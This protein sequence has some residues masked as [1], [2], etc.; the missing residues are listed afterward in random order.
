[1]VQHVPGNLIGLAR[2]T[3][4][5][6]VLLAGDTFHNAA[7]IRPSPHLH[8]TYPIPRAI[9]EDS[10]REI[11]REYFFAPDDDTDLSNR[12]IPF[13]TV[14]TNAFYFDPALSRVAQFKLGVF[15]SNPD[16]LVLSS[17]DPSMRHLLDFFPK[18][19][20]NWKQKGIKK[21]GVWEF[22]NSENVGYM[23]NTKA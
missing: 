9:L 5:T 1:M 7:Q 20:N 22:A 4:T 8:H 17:H 15:D 11:E 19:I 10:R 21:G 2:V 23:L 18:N 6:F 14:A 16:I 12:T 3:P 13:L